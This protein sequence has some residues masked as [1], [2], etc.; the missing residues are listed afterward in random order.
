MDWNKLQEL[1]L[2]EVEAT[3][4]ELPKPLREEAR[5][6]PVTFEHQQM[7]GCKLME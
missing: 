5:K 1:A 3:L 7:L 2:A 4:E 6:L